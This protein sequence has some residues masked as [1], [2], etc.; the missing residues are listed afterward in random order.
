MK[1]RLKTLSIISNIS[2]Y[3]S[4]QSYFEGVYSLSRVKLYR[5][6]N[7]LIVLS[8]MILIIEAYIKQSI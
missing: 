8:R 6:L 4:Q 1:F 5:F 2:Y 3:I 7:I